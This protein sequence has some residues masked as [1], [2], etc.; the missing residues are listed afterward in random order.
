MHTKKPKVSIVMATFNAKDFLHQAIESILSQSYKEFEFIIVDDGSTDSTWEIITQHHKIDQR[1]NPIKLKKNQGVAIAS[2]IGI[3][4][5]Q[6]KYIARMDSDDISLPQRLEKQ[7]EFMESNPEIGIL[8]SRVR[9]MNRAGNLLGFPPMPL[10]DLSIRWDLL[11]KN[12]FFNSST[13]FRKSLLSKHEIV[14]NPNARYGEDYDLWIRLLSLTKGE[15]LPDILLNYRIHSSNL[16][17]TTQNSIEKEVLFTSQA[18]NTHVKNESISSDKIKLLQRAIR[19]G[20]KNVK[21]QRASLVPIYM[22][23]WQSFYNQHKQNSN[24]F[25]LKQ[26]VLGDAALWILFP[27]FQKNSIKALSQLTKE[28]LMWPIYFLKSFFFLLRRRWARHPWQKKTKKSKGGG[29]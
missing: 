19:G 29:S 27:L 28:N 5:A 17:H 18:V 23:I 24:I 4:M 15:N 8:G 14:Y 10:K 2:N 25:K 26:K 16:T 1:I 7:V 22:E 20:Q 13:I 12:P 6:G 3:K 21:Y 11:F 9:Y